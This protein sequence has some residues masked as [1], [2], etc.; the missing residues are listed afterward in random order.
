MTVIPA[1][2]WGDERS[3]EFC[4]D[5]I[6]KGCTIAVSTLGSRKQKQAFM[7]GFSEMCRRLEPKNVLCYYRPFEEMHQMAQVIEFPYDGLE[8]RKPKGG[9]A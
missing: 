9:L 8:A 2:N 6:E 5:G 4:F 7:R 3:F 1:V